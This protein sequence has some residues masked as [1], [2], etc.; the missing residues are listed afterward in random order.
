M[1]RPRLLLVP[2]LTELEWVIKPQLEEWAEV[3]TYDAP[4]VG[5]EPPVEDPGS[6]ATARRGLAEAD[7]R[8]WDSFV[9]VADEFGVVG[10]GTPRGGCGR[11]AAGHRPRPRAGVEHGGRA[12]GRR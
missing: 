10:G 12:P 7:R 8:G 3:A 9:V 4:G 11:S 2:M 5:D 1:E 6:E